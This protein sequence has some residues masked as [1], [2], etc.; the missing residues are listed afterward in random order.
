MLVMGLT[1]TLDDFK[2]V[3]QDRRR[4]LAG[5]ILQYTIM[6][7]LGFVLGGVLGLEP[8][9][10][11]GLILVSCCPGGTA[12]NVVTFIAGADLP[13]SVAMTTASTLSATIMTPL[14]TQGLAGTIVPVDALALFRD[15]VNIVILPVLGGAALNST[16]PS[17]VAKISVVAPAIAV[18]VVA[19]ICA[20]TIAKSA[21][22]VLTAGPTLLVAI[23]LLH[24]G[25]FSLGYLVSKY[26]L[27]FDEKACRT[28]SIEVGMQNSTLGAVLALA[29]LHP[30][31]AVPCAI[32]ACMHSILGSA[33]AGLWRYKDS[34]DT[35][36]RRAA[37]PPYA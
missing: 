26:L 13:L 31:A 20:S 4:V 25:G 27:R 32:S 3:L 5:A 19:L 33:L 22:A 29:H 1:L 17:A 18:L 6:P 28:N 23:A 14:L 30:L 9:L 8:W 34:R 7:M 11:A 10:A 16:F 37:P 12:S 15:I 2:R 24:V 36:H 35:H 21:S